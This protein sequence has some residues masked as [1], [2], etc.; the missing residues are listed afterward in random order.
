MHKTAYVF[1]LLGVRSIEQ[2]NENISALDIHLTPQHMEYLESILPFELGAPHEHIVSLS[3]KF[4]CGEVL[5]DWMILRV[6]GLHQVTVSVQPSC[7]TGIRFLS[8][9][10]WFDLMDHSLV[11]RHYPPSNPKP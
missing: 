6:L 1:P 8:R 4:G 7:L 11:L 9:F 10:V 5:T 2:L 3:V